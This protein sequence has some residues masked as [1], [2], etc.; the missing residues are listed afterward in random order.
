MKEISKNEDLFNE[1]KEFLC[2]ETL[3]QFEMKRVIAGDNTLNSFAECLCYADCGCH[4][5]DNIQGCHSNPSN[6]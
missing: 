5:R 1:V 4:A 3:S 2:E 6:P